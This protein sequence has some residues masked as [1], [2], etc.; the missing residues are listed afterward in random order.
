LSWPKRTAIPWGAIGAIVLLVLGEHFVTRHWLELTDPVSLSWRYSTQVAE[1]EARDCQVLCLG[2]SLVKHGL[3]PAVFERV[4]G[5]RVLNVSAAQA[6]T[7]LTHSLLRRAVDAGARPKALIINAKPAVL[8]GGPECNIRSWQEI[9]SLRDGLELLDVTRNPPFVASTLVGR[10]LP[11]LR[12]RLAIQA[13]VTA[14]LRGHTDRIRAINAILWRNWSVNGGA[15]V[16]SARVSFDGEVTA[17]V[18]RQLYTELFYVDPA[19]ARAMERTIRLAADRRIPVYWVLPPLAPKLQALRDQSG[20]ER[21]HDEFLRSMVARY[22][23]GVTVLD[24]RRSGYPVAYFVDATHLNRHGALA[25]SYAVAEIVA[26]G[27]RSPHQAVS[28][29]GWIELAP[30]TDR[31]AIADLEIEDVDQ[32]ARVVQPDPDTRVSLR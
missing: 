32:S 29:P 27:A 14:A 20:A 28:I 30:P 4:S 9:L 12:S 10:L 7:I 13:S 2:D 15:N 21:L 24:A 6:S 1:Y 19:N 18:R 31:S 26:A 17:E 16:A 25:L 22:A 23:E 11:S 3:I 5:D 8:L